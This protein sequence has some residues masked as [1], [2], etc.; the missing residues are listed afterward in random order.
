MSNGYQENKIY[1]HCKKCKKRFKQNSP[2]HYFCSKECRDL[3]NHPKKKRILNCLKCKKRF[4]TFNRYQKY[5]SEKCK[6]IEKT[7]RIRERRF[8]IQNSK[9]I[10]EILG[11]RCL[12][13]EKVANEFHH[14]TYNIKI[15]KIRRSKPKE[16]HK[17]LV[18]YCKFLEP[19]CFS[20]HQKEHNST[21]IS[22]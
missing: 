11:K 7:K 6:N 21:R 12:D 19:L 5:C 8:T 14:K 13:C 15:K 4:K 20:C 3:F 1:K 17:M 9:E 22:L 10:W 16:F 2:R 18:K